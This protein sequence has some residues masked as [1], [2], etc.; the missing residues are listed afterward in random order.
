MKD[1]PKSQPTKPKSPTRDEHFPKIDAAPEQLAQALLRMKPKKP[2][3][4][5]Y[6]KDLEPRPEKPAKPKK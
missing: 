1:K 4:W 3:E 5:D 2:G 6:M